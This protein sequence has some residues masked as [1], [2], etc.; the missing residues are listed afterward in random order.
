MAAR[1]DA[2]VLSLLFSARS[3]CA[4]QPWRPPSYSSPS[5]SLLSSLATELPCLQQ[6]RGVP[7]GLAPSSRSS[8]R[9]LSTASAGRS[10]AQALE[11]RRNRDRDRAA[12]R[13][14]RGEAR[15]S[16]PALR[17]GLERPSRRGRGSEDA[18]QFRVC[19]EELQADSAEGAAE[20][21]RLPTRRP[22]KRGG[23][24]GA[25]HDALEDFGATEPGAA[26]EV[27]TA[28]APPPSQPSVAR[29][30]AC[31]LE[32]LRPVRV[33]RRA[34]PSSSGPAPPL[35]EGSGAAGA[36]VALPGD[37]RAARAPLAPPSPSAA[38]SSAPCSPPCAGR[39]GSRSWGASSA[40]FPSPPSRDFCGLVK[41]AR[42]AATE[43]SLVLRLAGP[44]RAE[45][46]KA[47]ALLWARLERE[48]LGE[49][50]LLPLEFLAPAELALLLSWCAR[51]GCF[52]APLFVR[53]AEIAAP[54]LP[55]WPARDVQTLVLAVAQFVAAQKAGRR[56]APESRGAQG[57]RGE[58]RPAGRGEYARGS[59]SPAAATERPRRAAATCLKPD[60]DE[61]SLSL[62]PP[63]SLKLPAVCAGWASPPGSSG[64]AHSLSESTAAALPAWARVGCLVFS[65]ALQHLVSDVTAYRPRHLRN[66]LDVLVFHEALISLEVLA[67][68]R[69]AKAASLVDSP[70]SALART[71]EARGRAPEAPGPPPRLEDGGTRETPAEREE[72]GLHA[73][74]ISP[75]EGRAVHPTE[76]LADGHAEERRERMLR[77]LGEEPCR[78]LTASSPGGNAP[79]RPRLPFLLAEALLARAHLFP[80]AGLCEVAFFFFT[81]AS[82]DASSA[83]EKALDAQLATP[84]SGFSP[85]LSAAS[86]AASAAPA[87]PR[88]ASSSAPTLSAASQ[89][90]ASRSAASAPSPSLSG[91][92]DLSLLSSQVAAIVAQRLMQ[93]SAG[94]AASAKGEFGNEGGCS[95]TRGDSGAAGGVA[96]AALLRVPAEDAARKATRA[97]GRFP[98]ALASPFDTGP[99]RGDDEQESAESHPK[100]PSTEEASARPVD[101]EAY[102]KAAHVFCRLADAAEKA[103]ERGKKKRRQKAGDLGGRGP[104]RTDGAGGVDSQ[105]DADA[106]FW[107]A[108][109]SAWLLPHLKAA[110]EEQ[111]RQARLLL[112][113]NGPRHARALESPSPPSPPPSASV[114]SSLSSAAS[115]SSLPFS[116]TYLSM[117]ANALTFC[118]SSAPLPP[119]S[120]PSAPASAPAAVAPSA[121][122]ASAALLSAVWRELLSLPV[123]RLASH[124]FPLRSLSLTAAAAARCGALREEE[125]TA[126]LVTLLAPVLR[127]LERDAGRERAKNKTQRGEEPE[128]PLRGAQ[129]AARAGE[130]APSERKAAAVAPSVCLSEKLV[131]DAYA[132]IFAKSPASSGA[133]HTLP[134]L[135]Q[136]FRLLCERVDSA[137]ESV[138]LD[139]LVYLLRAFSNVYV[140][141]GSI[142]PPPQGVSPPRLEATPPPRQAPQGDGASAPEASLTS[143]QASL[144][145]LFRRA[146]S[147]RL[148]AAFLGSAVSP[149]ASS[150]L[151]PDCVNALLAACTRFGRVP[152]ELVCAIN[153]ELTGFSFAPPVP[154][155]QAS[156]RSRDAATARSLQTPPPDRRPDLA[157]ARSAVFGSLAANN[158]PLTHV[159]TALSA[160]SRLPFRLRFSPQWDALE[161]ALVAHLQRPSADAAVPSPSTAAAPSPPT[162]ATESP[163]AAGSCSLSVGDL[164]RVL[165]TYAYALREPPVALLAALPPTLAPAARTFLVPRT[166][167]APG[168]SGVESGRGGVNIGEAAEGRGAP[169]RPD[170]ERTSGAPAAEDL[171]PGSGGVAGEAV[172]QANGLHAGAEG[173]RVVLD[174]GSG[175]PRERAAGEDEAS[176]ELVCMHTRK[177]LE[178]LAR[179]DSH[180]RGVP[181]KLIEALP[182]SPAAHSET[183]GGG[184]AL[185]R[186]PVALQ[187]YRLETDPF[188]Q[189]TDRTLS[190]FTRLISLPF[191]SPLASRPLLLHGAHSPKGTGSA[192]DPQAF[193]TETPAL[194]PRGGAVASAACARSSLGSSLWSVARL[195]AIWFP[196][197]VN[198]VGDAAS[199][200]T[201]LLCPSVFFAALRWWR[202]LRALESFEQAW[203]ADH[204]RREARAPEKLS[205][206]ETG[207]DSH[208]G[209]RQGNTDAASGTR[210]ERDGDSGVARN[211]RGDARGNETEE[212]AQVRWG[213]VEAEKGSSPEA[214]LS[215]RECDRAASSSP[216]L[217]ADVGNLSAETYAVLAGGY[218]KTSDRLPS[219]DTAFTSFASTFLPPESAPSA[220]PLRELDNVR[221]A[222]FLC[223]IVTGVFDFLLPSGE[224]FQRAAPQLNGFSSASALGSPAASPSASARPRTPG[225]AAARVARV[226]SLME[227]DEALLLQF[228]RAA[229]EAVRESDARRMQRAQREGERGDGAPSERGRTSPPAETGGA[230]L[231]DESNCRPLHTRCGDRADDA[232]LTAVECGFDG[233]RPED[234]RRP[235]PKPPLPSVRFHDEK[236]EA[237][238]PALK[239]QNSVAE[240]IEGLTRDW[241]SH[242]D[243]ALQQETQ[244]MLFTIDILL[245][246]RPRTAPT[247]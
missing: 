175:S 63:F 66:V 218:A 129:G 167:A 202:T 71:P 54:Q 36:R 14:G 130:G 243:F 20:P 127:C 185:E 60:A 113:R 156:A 21:R 225:A 226:L 177:A 44:A 203:I 43:A 28:H 47:V 144:V 152:V 136:L 184:G 245:T 25:R 233:D 118:P 166:P 11:R 180:T 33:P 77:S 240:V 94:E 163:D 126:V 75:P 242:G 197:G 38:S 191:A 143:L 244:S 162:C 232:Q 213:E 188:W 18:A 97:R 158:L 135:A 13:D 23:A 46:Q 62:P 183:E 70:T 195:Q 51:G 164:A 165:Q 146:C 35:G 241:E 73:R 2:R 221:T 119:L 79:H 111:H 178:S 41:L 125:K 82:R 15:A 235:A 176:L 10:T 100:H 109:L 68:L 53:V 89:A 120:P 114:P 174:E 65:A 115:A 50:S 74:P 228:L 29:V 211:S 88:T 154:L 7:G 4:P 212:A 78:A 102:A 189:L 112:Q 1:G 27:E 150:G 140:G 187:V 239:L 141:L 5:T 99:R 8:C 145:A 86:F 207:A 122:T 98:A 198:T 137:L 172:P 234:G 214:G 132:T 182:R 131:A 190:V 217:S 219:F 108:F 17:G 227:S 116:P 138:P 133:F 32:T 224:H 168:R 81:L 206:P 161:H 40:S 247:P 101:G 149:S 83:C 121:D 237:R 58:E 24:R 220:F 173:E 231:H 170:A 246:P 91:C 31:P 87:T 181:R 200:A 96:A 209:P 147:T 6:E 201:V 157:R 208:G 92:Y 153:K 151:P 139:I 49:S 45:K 52:S 48:A 179:L 148:S 12:P 67:A 37:P 90:W 76:R 16:S 9:Q 103:R 155:P 199:C 56:G 215:V 34:A 229:A 210:G 196:H 30:S 3:R 95:A 26:E 55:L 22:H 42:K 19:V 84:A 171:S 160:L 192:P 205:T 72:R 128:E 123:L 39:G 64:L 216:R 159:L 110:L 57:D 193:A 61:L 238:S 230:W 117:L 169:E 236:D 104:V 59:E 69:G 93:A 222:R 85:R 134:G 107:Q 204:R 223:C 194:A 105:C 142:A 186:Q 106:Q 80:P 124:E